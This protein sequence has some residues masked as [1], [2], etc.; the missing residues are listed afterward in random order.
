MFSPSYKRLAILLAITF[1][2]IPGLA[3]DP[4]NLLIITGGHDFQ[5]EPFF[6]MF[7]QMQEIDYTE[8]QHPQARQLFEDGRA[9]DY[10]V[11]LMYDMWQEITPEQKR[12]FL[13]YLDSGK[14]LIVLHHALASYQD[15]PTFLDIVGGTYILNPDGREIDDQTHPP[16]VYKHDVEM[17]INLADKEHP[18]TQGISPYRILDETYG[19]MYIRPGVH[20]LLTCNHPTSTGIV[21]WT[22]NYKQAKVVAIQGGHDQHAY[23][24]PNFSQLVENAIHD[25]AQPYE[26]IALFNGEDLSNW[27]ATGNADWQVED[28]LLIGQQGENNAPGDLF[29]HDSF[30]NFEL[31]AEFQMQWPANSGIW[32]R[33]QN[34]QRAYQADI[35]EY[36]DPECYSGTLYCPGQMFLAMNED[37]DLVDRDGWN[38]L[39]VRCMDNHIAIDLNGTQ[40]ANL[41]DETSRSGKV[42]I[43][44]HA[45]DQFKDMQIKLRR[46]D[47]IEL[48]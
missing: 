37:K 6:A 21:G 25:A 32:F 16:S 43:Q 23:Q 35:L 22:H 9:A 46:L 19:K 17:D 7:D 41:R 48:E 31:T 40:V 24:N 8:R 20:P 10:D 47:L 18:I 27:E 42:G 38:T 13:Q 45:G 3:A 26:K 15:W 14:G 34:E 28:G 5:R 29:T 33:Y 39:H 44:I 1:L 36:Q 4:I 11:I 2:S 12:G 30:R